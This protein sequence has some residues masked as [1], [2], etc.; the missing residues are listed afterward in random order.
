MRF[1]RAFR[2][3]LVSVA[4]TAAFLLSPSS[5]PADPV[6]ACVLKSNGSVRIVSATTVCDSRKETPLT[7]NTAGPQGPPGP[8]ALRY[9]DANNQLVGFHYAQ[10]L[11]VR[12]VGVANDPVSFSV[13]IGGVFANGL[14]Y[15]YEST[16]CSGPGYALADP[17]NV[18]RAG[19]ALTNSTTLRYAPRT[20]IVRDLRSQLSLNPDGLPQFCT[21]FGDPLTRSVGPFIEVALPT[22]AAPVKLMQ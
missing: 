2:S 15:F 20:G 11:T 17:N 13:N 3:A 12:F 6:Y 7:W 22:F 21:P 8:G 5:A 1:R 16:D 19:F 14:Y 18:V 9:V 10:G 4:G